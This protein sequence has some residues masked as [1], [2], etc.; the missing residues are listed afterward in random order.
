MRRRR[1]LLF[2][3]SHVSLQSAHLITFGSCL[4]VHAHTISASRDAILFHA[5][6][7]ISHEVVVFLLLSYVVFNRAIFF[8]LFICKVMHIR[9]EWMKYSKQRKV[10]WHPCSKCMRRRRRRRCA[11]FVKVDAIVSTGSQ[12]QTHSH[13]QL[14]VVTYWIRKWTCRY[15]FVHWNEN[16]ESIFHISL[17]FVRWSWTANAIERVSLAREWLFH[18]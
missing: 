11:T 2:R 17:L 8:L 16:N 12:T 7:E 6:I 3:F 10:N 1:I 18:I 14:F 13:N 4:A 9:A 5:I 15:H